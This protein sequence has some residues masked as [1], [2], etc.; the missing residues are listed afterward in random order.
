LDVV[1][2]GLE[3]RAPEIRIE[4]ALAYFRLGGDAAKSMATLIPFL[5]PRQ[6]APSDIGLALIGI[7][8]IRWPIEQGAEPLLKLL[9][10]GPTSEI[11]QLA[12]D[13]LQRSYPN[14]NDVTDAF[15]DRLVADRDGP[16]RQ[17]ILSYLETR[18]NDDDSRGIP[19]IEVTQAVRWL[20]ENWSQG[21]AETMT[22][23]RE[24]QV[25]LAQRTLRAAGNSGAEAVAE[26]LVDAGTCPAQAVS[27]FDDLGPAR[28]A[29]IP[30][31]V[32]AIQRAEPEVA[33]LA[34]TRLGEMRDLAQPAFQAVART[35]F[36]E[37]EAALRK[38]DPKAYVASTARWGEW[39]AL[40]GTPMV[41]LVWL[42]I[43][44]GWTKSGQSAIMS[45][46][47][48]VARCSES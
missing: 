30:I 18:L 35:Q 21:S 40:W 17:T 9:K 8:E 43:D 3:S 36:P 41:L 7:A 46:A 20:R 4:A 24:L 31:F 10:M 26:W 5:E 32:R 12:A 6:N 13:V 34:V 16:V 47:D 1:S 29:A 14:D 27:L 44:W 22:G 2:R 42:M 19:Q 38:I 11:R 23:E 37:T 28:S 48:G 15:A 39:Y 25:W 33:R 45:S